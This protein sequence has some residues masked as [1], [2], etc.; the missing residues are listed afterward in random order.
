MVPEM[1]LIKKDDLIKINGSTFLKE[2]IDNRDLK[3]EMKL[4]IN[5]VSSI[6]LYKAFCIQK[7]GNSESSRLAFFLL[8]NFPDG[9]FIEKNNDNYKCHIFEL[10]YTGSGDLKRLTNQLFSGYIHCKTLLTVLNIDPKQISFSFNV[11]CVR[12]NS[13]QTQ[14]HLMGNEKKIVPGEEIVIQDS[15]L[16]DWV[17]D[18]LV[19]SEGNYSKVLKI[20]KIILQKKGDSLY[21]SKIDF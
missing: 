21:S 17:Y 11:V 15:L 3:A 18:R 12:E 8:N 6:E 9:I 7:K 16:N 4:D 2:Q 14:Y 5:L 10:K 13:K 19:Y 1:T 20:K